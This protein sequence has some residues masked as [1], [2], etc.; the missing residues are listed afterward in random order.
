MAR[1]KKDPLRPLTAGERSWLERV[2]HS[3]A[4][5]AG[6]VARA[7]ALLAVADG[8]SYTEAAALAGRRVGDTVAAWEARFNREG[9][10]A[11]APGHGGGP[12][13]RY[14]AEERARILAEFRRPRDRE[15]DGTATWSLA[16]LRRALRGAPDG[17]PGVSIDT[18][19]RALR[20]GGL[21]WQRDRSWCETGV[22]LRKRK[23]GVAVVVDPDAAAKRT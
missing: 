12:P 10:A 13:A 6:H 11:L 8:R 7:R 21:T 18:V 4:E 22:V 1:R 9:L 15:R 20:D 3:R 14:G 19:A 5:P 17:L 2:S 16:T 23:A